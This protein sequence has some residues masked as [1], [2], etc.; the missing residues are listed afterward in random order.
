MGFG[1]AIA[2]ISCLTGL[3]PCVQ[4]QGEAAGSLPRVASAPDPIYPKIALAARVSGTVRVHVTTDGKHISS[5]D[6]EDGPPM[7]IKSTEDNLRSWLFEEHLPTSFDVTFE[8]KLIHIQGCEEGKR[9]VILNLPTR[10]EI[11]DAPPTCDWERFGRQQ[12]YL[13]EQHVYPLEM[14]LTIDGNPVELPSEVV[15]AN[16]TQTLTISN[17]EGLFLVLETMA[18]GSDL[19]LRATICTELIEISGIAPSAVEEVWSIELPASKSGRE[20]GLPKGVHARSACIISFDPLDGDGTGMIVDPC[21]F[22][23]RQ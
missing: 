15:L 22:P 8:Y 10:V 6:R 3:A 12:K 11:D 20:E 17:T 2:F 16:S 7:L 5:I 18:T 19:T 14:H 21:R 23:N 4:A 13:R 1:A 9:G